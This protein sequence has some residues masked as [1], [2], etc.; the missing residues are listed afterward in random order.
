MNGSNSGTSGAN[1]ATVTFA[2][3]AEGDCLA[4]VTLEEVV[5]RLQVTFEGRL[6]SDIWSDA[7]EPT[8]HALIWWP[9]D[10]ITGA[11]IGQPKSYN[12]DTGTWI[13]LGNAP[14]SGFKARKRANGVV[15]LAAGASSV[16]VDFTS[17]GTDA[18][19]IT[20]TPQTLAGS[21]WNPAP[22]NMNNF[23]LI[24]TNR[25]VGQFTVAAF[26]V[27]TGGISVAW[28]VAEIAAEEPA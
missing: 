24:V 26:A 5:R 25:A 7:T 3:K 15:A 10:P 2:P 12:V 1:V 14:N 22:A 21:T 27:P 13:P 18:Y 17:I 8:D 16:N 9:K 28:E 19:H 23:G 4:N 20:L 11:R 6:T